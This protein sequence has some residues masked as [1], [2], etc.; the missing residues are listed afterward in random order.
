MFVAIESLEVVG[1]DDEETENSSRATVAV[2]V[3]GG[4]VKVVRA[5]VTRISSAWTEGAVAE[6]VVES[7][8]E[9]AKDFAV[10]VDVAPGVAEVS[11][12]VGV[13]PVVTAIS[14]VFVTTD[15]STS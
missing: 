11:S 3:I 14:A 9:S 7:V 5:K 8:S 13:S 4:T 10:A 6:A 2:L 15:I 12:V 1:I